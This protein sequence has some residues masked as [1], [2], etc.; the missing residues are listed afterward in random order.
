MNE[1]ASGLANLIARIKADG[2]EAGETERQARVEAASR[3]AERLLAK[4]R[5]EADKIVAAANA[6]AERR[7][8]QLDAEL[9]MAARDFLFRLQERLSAQV[10]AP[11]T[12]ALA[13]RALA[14]DAAVAAL[15]VTLLG[16]RVQGSQLTTDSAQRAALEAA[17]MRQIS[18]SAGDAG[19]TITDESGLGGFR[20]VRAGEHFAWDVS[21]DAVAREL[22]RLVEPSLRRA[23]SPDITAG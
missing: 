20:L 17:V 18:A 21:Q 22:A 11:A 14:D 12:R 7:R 10:I 23:L 9:R 2:V 15:I 4:A 13:E 6:E 16:D 5:A 1:T 19:I 3:E 8:H